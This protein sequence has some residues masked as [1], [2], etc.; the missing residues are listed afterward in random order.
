MGYVKGRLN[1]P[2][3]W[4]GI[5]LAVTGVQQGLQGGL[6]VWLAV[7]MGVGGVLAT[8]LREKGK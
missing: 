7:I 2:S 5:G 3:T 1:E 4:A 8:A 6:P